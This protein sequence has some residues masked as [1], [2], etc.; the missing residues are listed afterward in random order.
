MNK[1]LYFILLPVFAILLAFNC[2]TG[3]AVH[4]KGFYPGFAVSKSIGRQDIPKPFSVK[5]DN[6]NPVKSN[7]RIKAWENT[8]ATILPATFVPVSRHF[9]R[10]ETFF[11]K[12]IANVTSSRFSHLS[13]RGPPSLI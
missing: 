6:K 11:G 10:S 1:R 12:Y 8:I 4:A 2:R 9:F 13:S 3:S 5:N 7:I